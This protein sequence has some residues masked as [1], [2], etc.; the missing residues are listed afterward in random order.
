MENS[1]LDP[2]TDRKTDLQE[3]HMDELA[4]AIRDLRN[5]VETGDG[6]AIA[7]ACGDVDV[8]AIR[9]ELPSDLQTSI[10]YQLKSI[11]GNMRFSPARSTRMHTLYMV[12]CLEN[13]IEEEN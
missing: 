4:D 5:A 11:E 13:L 7:R 2:P 10:G 3:K 6:S 12:N 1:M 8:D 9:A